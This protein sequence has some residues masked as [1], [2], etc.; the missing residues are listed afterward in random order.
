MA[1]GIQGPAEGERI[2][3]ALRGKSAMFMASHGVIVVAETVAFLE[4]VS[5]E[6]RELEGPKCMPTHVGRAFVSW[7]K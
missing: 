4:R 3:E 5:L 7:K 2:A 1:I 6:P